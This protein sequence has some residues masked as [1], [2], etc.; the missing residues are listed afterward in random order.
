MNKTNKIIKVILASLLLV[1][2][3]VPA[4]V[5]AADPYGV[6]DVNIDGLTSKDIR[7]AASGVIQSLLGV[8]GLLALVIILYGGFRW[9]TS[10][11]SEDGIT[12]AKKTIGAGIIGLAIILFAYAIV[13]FVFNVLGKAT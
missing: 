8:L 3:V 13:S 1:C 6:N 11:G 12:S 9:M 7:S 2:L 5:A 10:G 4:M